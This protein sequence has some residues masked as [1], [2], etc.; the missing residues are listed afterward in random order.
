MKAPTEF[1]RRLAALILAGGDFT[2]DAVTECGEIAR[3]RG[4]AQN[5]TQNSIG[6]VI[7]NAASKGRIEFTGE[8]AKA[9][10]PHRKGGM[11]RVWRGTEAGRLWAANVL[12]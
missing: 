9:C 8:I 4:H 10:S 2:I 1:E 7:R 5:G 3:D 11:I 6:S 12:R